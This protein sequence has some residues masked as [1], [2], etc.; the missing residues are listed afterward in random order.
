VVLVF[1]VPQML[2]ELWDSHKVQKLIVV[3]I[4]PLNADFG[5]IPYTH[6]HTQTHTITS[7]HILSNKRF[8]L[9]DKKTK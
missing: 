6:S 2:A 9:L 1:Q 5:N 4:R 8:Q 3:A 7:S